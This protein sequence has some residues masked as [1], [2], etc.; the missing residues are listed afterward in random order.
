VNVV[1]SS[2]WLEYIADG[3][4]AEYFEAPINSTTELL[5]P[6]IVLYEVYKRLLTQIGEIR[7]DAAI[8]TM[9]EGQVVDLDSTLGIEA[10]LVSTRY[11]LAMADSII[12]ATARQ[13][14]A[15]LWTQDADFEGMEGVQYRAPRG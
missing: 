8:N 12:L 11:R 6:S 7:A 5:V 3:P 10:A 1:D 15:V 13:N 2:A 14:G 9:M 4:N